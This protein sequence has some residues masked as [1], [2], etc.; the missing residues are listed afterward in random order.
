M[1]S[2][3]FITVGCKLNQFE[4]EQMRE[5]AYRL[6]YV[7][8]SDPLAADVCVVN[9]CTVTSKSDYRSRQAVR[10]VLRSN[11][12]ALVVVTGCYAQRSPEDLAAIAG[13]D[14]VLGNPEKDDIEAYLGLSKQARPLVKTGDPSRA[15]L[16]GST[17]YLH[18]FGTYTR[19]FVKIQ[20]GCDNRCAYCAVPAARGASRSKQ[21]AEVR[22]EVETLVGEGYR[23]IVLTGVHLG[24]Y[25]KDLA[26]KTSLARLLVALADID[27]LARLRLSSV[28]P[29]DLT[30][31][32][33]QLA[34]DRS[35]KVCSHFHVP[36]QSGDDRVLRRMGRP[37]DSRFYRGVIDKITGSVSRCGVGADVM[38][39]F[40]GEDQRAFA[41]TLDLVRDLG[42]TYLH[43]FS[44]SVRPGTPACSLDG[45]VDP[46][47]RSR[48]SAELRRVGR[49]KGAAFRRSLVGETIDV[50]ILGKADRCGATGLAGNYVKVDFKAA[51]PANTLVRARVV[52]WAEGAVWAEPAG[53]P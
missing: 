2:V 18:G 37:Y 42:L 23:E 44:F 14:V 29:T 27:G 3:G 4:T 7:A 33:I 25:G 16:A 6:G 9:T 36:L 51:L 34:A 53:R 19:A 41:N 39:G 40:P 50:L 20:D 46:E 22:A 1:R 38:V 32:L 17:R 47:T 30:D 24:A 48:R 13:V 45:Q 35:S 49:E 21:A 5:A 12:G 52:D 15:N 11:P 26:P 31:E 43:V 8:D 10:R 28:E